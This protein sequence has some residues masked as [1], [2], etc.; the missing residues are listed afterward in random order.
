MLPPLLVCPATGLGPRD[1]SPVEVVLLFPLPCLGSGTGERPG[2]S[3]VATTRDDA[4]QPMPM[5]GP[6]TAP[7]MTRSESES[8]RQP[9]KE[10]G[11]R[12][13]GKGG[14]TGGVRRRV[15]T[16][17]SQIGGRKNAPATTHVD[18]QAPQGPGPLPPAPR[19]RTT[20]VSIV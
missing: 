8:E 14:R 5:P 17:Q 4:P 18:P 3:P 10:G 9:Q 20:P 13:G 15:Q 12:V 16:R 2:A 1:A 7:R 6:T 19:A 11:G